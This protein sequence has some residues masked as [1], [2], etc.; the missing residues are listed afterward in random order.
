MTQQIN[1]SK[2]S[3]KS[4]GYDPNQPRVPAGQEGGGRW[5][6]TGGG[7]ADQPTQAEF[8][9]ARLWDARGI[10]TG[11]TPVV[12]SMAQLP[13]VKKGNV[14]IA[15][16]TRPENVPSIVR[17]GLR[18]GR[19]VGMGERLGMVLGIHGEASSFGEISVVYDVPAADA[20]FVNTSW[21]EVYR[22]IQPKEIKGILLG[23]LSTRDIPL[24]ASIYQEYDRRSG[25]AG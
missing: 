22:P 8:V 25:K 20:H 21:V 15:H 5:T 14:R 4:R 1:I 2:V 16:G 19:D 6:S 23:N 10:D 7:R 9:N 13:P 12:T 11:D 17:D 18:P 24:L 3:V